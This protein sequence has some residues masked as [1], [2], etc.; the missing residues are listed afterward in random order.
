MLRR[1]QRAQTIVLLL[2]IAGLGAPW[3]VS[4]AELRDLRSEV[5]QRLQNGDNSSNELKG[6]LKAVQ[7]STKELQSK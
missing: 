6:V 2:V 3:W 1:R 4:H 7:E 5:A